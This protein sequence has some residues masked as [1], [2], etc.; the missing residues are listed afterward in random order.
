MFLLSFCLP[1][2]ENEKAL[3]F[4]NKGRTENNPLLCV[5]SF[6]R[7][8]PSVPDSN[9]LSRSSWTHRSIAHHHR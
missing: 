1:V 8:I 9:Q 7:T 6:I 4:E 2:E 3:Y 5:V